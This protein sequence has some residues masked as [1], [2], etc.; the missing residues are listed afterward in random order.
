MMGEGRKTEGKG[1]PTNSHFCL[2]QLLGCSL[3]A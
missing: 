2:R 1:A 3:S